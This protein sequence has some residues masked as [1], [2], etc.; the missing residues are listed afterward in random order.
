MTTAICHFLSRKMRRGAHLEMHRHYQTLQT[1]TVLCAAFFLHE[2]PS[3]ENPSRCYQ[4]AGTFDRENHRNP[5]Q[6]VFFEELVNTRVSVLFC[7][8]DFHR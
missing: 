4:S 2:S 6:Q 7:G 1:Y 3:N 8:E 5:P